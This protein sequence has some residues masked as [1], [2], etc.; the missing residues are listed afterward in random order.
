MV[1]VTTMTNSLSA[2]EN[3]SRTGFVRRRCPLAVALGR[4]KS[5]Y[6]GLGGLDSLSGTFTS[7]TWARRD[8]S[9]TAAVLD[10]EVGGTA[11]GREVGDGEA[12]GAAGGGDSVGGGAIG[13]T[14]PWVES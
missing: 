5:T 10:G 12:G 4:A 2:D 14:G 7:N 13:R 9:C 11:G 8:A 3:R 1:S 6:S